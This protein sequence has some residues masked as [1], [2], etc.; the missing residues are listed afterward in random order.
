[1]KSYLI[2]YTPNERGRG[3]AALDD[4]IKKFPSSWRILD[5]AW[6]VKTDWSPRQVREHIKPHIDVAD[7]LLV[8]E[9]SGEGAWTGLNDD[10]VKWLMENL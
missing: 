7:Q 10:T 8:L 3:N 2:A 5:S 4:A 9:F 6:I 1:M